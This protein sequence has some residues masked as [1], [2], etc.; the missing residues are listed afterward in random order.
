[1]FGWEASKL[2]IALF[3]TLSRPPLVALFHHVRVTVL[4][5]DPLPEPELPLVLLVPPP[6]LQAAS[7]RLVAAAATTAATARLFII[8][9]SSP[10]GVAALHIAE[11]FYRYFR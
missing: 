4:E 8:E 10:R 3:Q 11:S 5:L 2:L 7:T 1:M 6:L 9:C